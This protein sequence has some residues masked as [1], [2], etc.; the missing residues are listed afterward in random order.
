VGRRR[1]ARRGL[2]CASW[3]LSLLALT[4]GVLLVLSWVSRLL[5]SLIC[6][7]VAVSAKSSVLD[8]RERFGWT[9][10]GCALFGP[11][12]KRFCLLATAK[13]VSFS[14]SSLLFLNLFGAPVSEMA[15]CVRSH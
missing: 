8:F 6:V 10:V 4:Q 7:G 15:V 2:F 1:V 11:V 9:G 12:W 14:A 3:V 13:S 5:H